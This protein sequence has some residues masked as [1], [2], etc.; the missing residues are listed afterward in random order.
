MNFL[1]NPYRF[2]PVSGAC[3]PIQGNNE[4]IGSGTSTTTSTPF[5]GLYDYSVSAFIWEDTEFA[6]NEI[7]IEGIELDLIGWTTSYPLNN[8]SIYMAYVVENTFD[9][10]PAIN[11]SDL[12][13]TEETLVFDG[14]LS[15]TNGWFTINFNQ[16][17][18]CYDP[19][20]GLNCYMRIENRDGTWQTGFGSCR[21]S[22]SPI[23]KAMYWRAD[24]AYPTG[25][26]QRLNA[27]TNIRFK[28]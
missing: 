21:Y 22:P 27:R 2:S 19:N 17:N 13:L 14:N 9:T 20:T 25:N 24:G 1:I 28:K 18:F 7:Q 6:G 4:Q 5:Y 26:G 16:S 8:V 11:G 12:T 23:S 15:I 10:S 3:A